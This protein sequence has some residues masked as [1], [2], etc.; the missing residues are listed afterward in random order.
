ALLLRVE[1][2]LPHSVHRPSQPQ[3]RRSG[4]WD[5]LREHRHKQRLGRGCTSTRSTQHRSNRYA[6]SRSESPGDLAVGR[7]T[8]GVQQTLPL[9]GLQMRAEE[10]LPRD[11]QLD[12]LE[13]TPNKAHVD[14]G[15]RRQ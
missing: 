11:T 15:V 1:L 14:S 6:V 5:R 4:L 7:A 8:D 10:I 12:I 13:P 9:T 3:L 2:L